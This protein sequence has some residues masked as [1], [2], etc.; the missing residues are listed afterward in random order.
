P[1]LDRLAAR[2]AVF[3]NAYSTCP[4]CMPAR[5]TIR[6]G[7]EPPTTRLWSNTAAYDDMHAAIERRCGPYLAATMG[8]LGYRTFG[9]GKFHTWPWEAPVGFDVQLYSEELY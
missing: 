2:G 5:Y 4:V 1:N 3:T 6:S 9:V 8:R 7:C